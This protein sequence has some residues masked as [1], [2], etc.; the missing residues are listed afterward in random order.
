M[1]TP[2]DQPV[3]NVPTNTFNPSFV[4]NAQQ[5]FNTASQNALPSAE[6]R[7]RASARLRSRLSGDLKGN[8]DQL[9]DQ[10]SNNAGLREKRSMQL[11]GASQ[12]ALSSGLAD[13]E[14]DYQRRRQEG[15]NILNSIGTSQIDAA[16]QTAGIDQRFFDLLLKQRLGLGELGIAQQNANTQQTSVLNDYLLGSERND[17]TAEQLANELL[18]GQGQLDNQSYLG[19]LSQANNFFQLF[20]QYGNTVGAGPEGIANEFDQRLDEIINQLGSVFGLT[21]SNIG[22]GNESIPSGSIYNLNP[23]AQSLIDI[24]LGENTPS[25]IINNN[26]NLV[27]STDSNESLPLPIDAQAREF[28]Q[29]FL[30]PNNDGGA[31]AFIENLQ[32]ALASPGNN[33]SYGSATASP[34][35]LQSAIQLANQILGGIE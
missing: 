11:F 15:A 4:N 16:N 8:L 35:L 19:Q 33:Y 3:Q 29:F 12:G 21:P 23:E 10:L 9:N 18:L 22:G 7:D 17:L 24:I 31:D 1:P 6:S 34:Q 30:A 32:A 26:G 27:F 25:R 14:D 2:Y 20:S 13:I 28:L 5:N